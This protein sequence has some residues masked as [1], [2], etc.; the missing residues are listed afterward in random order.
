MRYPCPFRP[1]GGHKKKDSRPG[2]HRHDKPPMRRIFLI[3][4]LAL[5][6]ILIAFGC[7]YKPYNL[8]RSASLAGYN[9]AFIDDR[10]AACEDAQKNMVECYGQFLKSFSCMEM[11]MFVNIWKKVQQAGGRVSYDLFTDQ[12]NQWMQGKEGVFNQYERFCKREQDLSDTLCWS[13]QSG[14]PYKREVT[15][16]VKSMYGFN[17]DQ[18]LSDLFQSCGLPYTPTTYRN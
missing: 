17:M 5:A 2:P 18:M 6:S 10:L 11:G 14:Q 13:D 15:I 3:C 8:S 12:E 4:G 1:P 16:E 7:A 9:P